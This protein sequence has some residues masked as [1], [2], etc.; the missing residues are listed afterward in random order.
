MHTYIHKYIHKY[1]YTYI[2]TYIHTYMH[3]CTRTCVHTVHACI[4]RHIHL[5]S[6][7]SILQKETYDID[8]LLSIRHSVIGHTSQ[9]QVADFE[10]T[11]GID[12]QVGWFE[13]AMNH[14]R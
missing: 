14:L 12:A 8:A 10:I 4:R 3:K 13:V 5:R 1:I 6:T 11:V 2:H 7:R 9:A